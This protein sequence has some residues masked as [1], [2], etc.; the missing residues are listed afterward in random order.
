LEEPLESPRFQ[1][2]EGSQDPTAKILA[3]IPNREEIEP[4]ETTSSRWA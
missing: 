2:N 1:G 3:E 4:E